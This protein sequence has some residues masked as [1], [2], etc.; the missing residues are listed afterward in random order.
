MLNHSFSFV[1]VKWYFENS[2]EMHQTNHFLYGVLPLNNFIN[3]YFTLPWQPNWKTTERIRKKCIVLD[4]N[5]FRKI[6]NLLLKNLFSEALVPF[7][8]TENSANNVRICKVMHEPIKLCLF[9]NQST[10][11]KNIIKTCF[12]ADSKNDRVI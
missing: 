8:E 7:L 9:S 3:L 1:P 10:K 5:N 6:S 2:N 4:L 11:L 12:T